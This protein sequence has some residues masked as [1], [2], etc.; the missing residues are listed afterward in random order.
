MH[1][2]LLVDLYSRDQIHDIDMRRTDFKRITDRQNI[3]AIQNSG[4]NFG[5]S[6][7]IVPYRWYYYLSG[8]YSKN[9]YFQSSS[10]DNV[11]IQYLVETTLPE[12]KNSQIDQMYE[13]H[14]I[15]NM[16]CYKVYKIRG[17]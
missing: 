4:I 17:R 8:K 13:K 12:Y 6:N 2:F 3:I 9:I 14:L 5:N 15:K 1:L 11:E 10:F 7:V 16:G